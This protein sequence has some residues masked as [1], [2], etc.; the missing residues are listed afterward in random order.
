MEEDLTKKLQGANVAG[1]T[2]S[3]VFDDRE[4][5]KWEDLIEEAESPGF[6][7]NISLCTVKESHGIAI[8]PCNANDHLQQKHHYT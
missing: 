6:A 7:T 2:E 5:V 1:E 4:D 3:K 8:Q